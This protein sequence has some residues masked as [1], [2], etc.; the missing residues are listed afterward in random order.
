MYAGMSVYVN[1]KNWLFGKWRGLQL[2]SGH[3]ES[4]AH[5]RKSYMHIIANIHFN[6]YVCMYVR[7]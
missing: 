5:V 7:F 4:A 1:H 3:N 2:L 6:L